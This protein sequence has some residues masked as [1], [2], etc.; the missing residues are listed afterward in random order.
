MA[1]LMLENPKDFFEALGGTHDAC[2]TSFIWE[3]TENE[4]RICID[5]LN[6]NFFGLPD[7]EGERPVE[8]IFLNT[9]LIDVDFDFFNGCLNIYDIEVVNEVDF[10]VSI[11]FSPGGQLKL[12]CQR[13]EVLD[14]ESLNLGCSSECE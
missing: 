3:K 1:K 2:V 14:K 9:T 8:I 4:F 7:Y 10:R 12:E 6:S 5:D 11:R 13:I